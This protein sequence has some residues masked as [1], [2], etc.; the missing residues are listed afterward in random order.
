MQILKIGT[1]NIQKRNRFPL[2]SERIE[3]SLLAAE[4]DIL[5]LQECLLEHDGTI[6]GLEKLLQS[7]PFQATSVSRKFRN[8]I[9]MGNAILSKLPLNHVRS[10]NFRHAR[11]MSQRSALA[12]RLE[13]EG[14]NYL[15]VS[16][17]LGLIE[18]ERSSQ[19]KDILAYCHESAHDFE[20]LV[21][22]GDFNDWSGQCHR[23]ISL[24]SHEHKNWS[25]LCLPEKISTSDLPATYPALFP[26]LALDRIYAWGACT[27][28]RVRTLS[29]PIVSDHRALMAEVR[30]K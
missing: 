19:L 15:L 23:T 7:F 27:V 5:F 11:G 9:W 8:G 6:I 14:R 25:A 16:L 22:A 17:H 2:K 10:L 3:R 29:Q 13:R 4:W 30:F 26:L 18:K 1:L 21:M 28:E 20:G 12:A 24:W